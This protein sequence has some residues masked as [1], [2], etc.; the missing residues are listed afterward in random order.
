MRCL[1]YQMRRD[2]VLNDKRGMFKSGA[3][4]ASAFLIKLSKVSEQILSGKGIEDAGNGRVLLL[5]EIKS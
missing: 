2:T 5:D 4:L 3:E 1:N